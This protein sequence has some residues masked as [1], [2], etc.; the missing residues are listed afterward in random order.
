M[1][2]LMYKGVLYGLS[3][4]NYKYFLRKVIW[5]HPFDLKELCSHSINLL[6]VIDITDID[7]E[8]ATKMLEDHQ[9]E[10]KEKLNEKT[11]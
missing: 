9:K 5:N 10:I 2:Y 4:Y 3:N 8:K 6:D 7:I 11:D 1:K